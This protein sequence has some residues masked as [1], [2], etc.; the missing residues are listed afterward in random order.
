MGQMFFVMGTVKI[1]EG[2][3]SSFRMTSQTASLI[4][5][6]KPRLLFPGLV[7]TIPVWMD[8]SPGINLL[9]NLFHKV[10]VGALQSE[11]HTLY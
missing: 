5:R 6:K 11:M 8:D 7:R 2:R 10:D 1:K 3:I 9:R 4:F